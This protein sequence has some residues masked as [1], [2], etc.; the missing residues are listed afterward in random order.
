MIM[1]IRAFT[2][3]ELLVAI[4]IVAIL[5]LLLFPFAASGLERARRVFCA[6]SLRQNYAATLAYATDHAGSLSSMVAAG[7]RDDFD[8]V[9]K[10]G[11]IMHKWGALYPDYMPAVDTFY[12]PSRK[13][14]TRYSRNPGSHGYGEESFGV[15]IGKSYCE[16]SY[17]HMTGKGAG[18]HV[19]TFSSNYATKV[20]AMDVF[21][22]D[23]PNGPGGAS[24]THGDQFYNILCFDGH[25]VGFF[26]EEGR[27]ETYDVSGGRGSVLTNQALPYIESKL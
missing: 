10:V 13:P 15:G 1:R 23:V 17:A 11:N 4:S 3:L 6:N 26:D 20:M 19:A 24:V 5:A 14:D 2:L 21:W 22:R 7:A 8:S 16:I 9:V 12:C 25:L 27:L 18:V